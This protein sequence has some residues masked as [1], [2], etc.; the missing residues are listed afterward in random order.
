LAELAGGRV[1]TRLARVLLTLPSRRKRQAAGSSW[2]PLTLN[3]QDLAGLAGTTTETC[4]RI[5]SGWAARGVLRVEP[6]GIRLLDRGALEMV[7]LRHRPWTHSNGSS[8]ALG[9]ESRNRSA[10]SMTTLPSL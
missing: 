7:A 8:R 5:I 3:R 4:I 1:A 9:R 6:G 2:I 10:A